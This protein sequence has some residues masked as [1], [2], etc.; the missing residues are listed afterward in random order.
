MS[1][2]KS[3]YDYTMAMKKRRDT[4]FS[5]T[6]ATQNARPSLECPV[7]LWSLLS[8]TPRVYRSV[9]YARI[10]VLE[11]S[12]NGSKKKGS[13]KSSSPYMAVDELVLLRMKKAFAISYAD[14]DVVRWLQVGFVQVGTHQQIAVLGMVVIIR[15]FRPRKYPL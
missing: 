2:Q 9:G 6:R 10:V 11:G 7:L 1:F 8:A 12:R 3:L 13:V 5:S 15:G 4:T 14:L